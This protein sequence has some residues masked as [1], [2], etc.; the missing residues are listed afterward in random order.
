MQ[1]PDVCRFYLN[2]HCKKNDKCRFKHVDAP[3]SSASKHTYTP[4]AAVAA[5][6]KKKRRP[7]MAKS[8]NNTENFDPCHDPAHMRVVFDTNPERLTINVQ[9]RDVVVAPC[10][11]NRRGDENMY[12]RLVAEIEACSIPQE[13]LLKSWHGDTHWIA[14]DSTGWK[15]Q[16]PTF[17][18][19]VKRIQEYFGLDIKATRFNW[20]KDTSEWKPFHHDAA[21]V[22]PDKALTQNFTVAVSFGVTRE[23]A[24]EEVESKKVISF[25]LP[26]GSVYCFARD[27]NVMWRHG[28]LQI[29]PEKQTNEGRISIIAWGWLDQTD[30]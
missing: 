1:D 9:S 6:N 30:V 7:P 19:I 4:A 28:I 3:T 10:M 5:N 24:F 17:V 16:C 23:A 13:N 2:G 15:K 29:P 20:Y 22:K 26:N 25:P 14:D 11:F 8:R 27:V 12:E 18:S 21:A